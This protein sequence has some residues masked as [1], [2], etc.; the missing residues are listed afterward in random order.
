MLA[1]LLL[2][3]AN[4]RPN[5]SSPKS[6][7]VVNAIWEF[8]KL[9]GWGAWLR[10][11]DLGIQSP[12]CYQLHHAPAIL[13]MHNY[14]SDFRQSEDESEKENS[15]KVTRLQQER[16]VLFGFVALLALLSI[17]WWLAATLSKDDQVA[18]QVRTVQPDEESNG[19]QI[20]G[21]QLVAEIPERKEKW[22]LQF[23]SSH[24]DPEEQVATT[25]NGICQVARNGE[26]VT[27]F[28]APTIIVRFK[29]REMEM[30]GD[31]II[32]AM[33]PRLKV[34]LRTLKWHWETGELVGTGKVKIEGERIS[35]IADRLE[36]DTTLQRISLLGNVHTDVIG[37][38][39][40]E[41]K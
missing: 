19:I 23:A 5:G 32:I 22:V 15:G 24:Y 36:G 34:T 20:S 16:W 9:I 2:S 28:R 35:M 12:A 18:L 17:A 11:R 6:V 1:P 26:V 30:L 14:N 21:G 8:D 4:L 39:S 13:L 27:V 41:R 7:E 10:T 3:A 37:S 31:V 38:R 33:L 40:G 25:K 29:D